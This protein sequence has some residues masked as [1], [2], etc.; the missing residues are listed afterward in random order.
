MPLRSEG[1]SFASADTNTER[2]LHAVKSTNRLSQ[3]PRIAPP[4]SARAAGDEEEG[5][6]EEETPPL[7]PVTTPVSEPF[8]SPVERIR[9]ILR[10]PTITKEE[11]MRI[12]LL[13]TKSSAHLQRII[14]QNPM[15][16]VVSVLLTGIGLG[17]LM[18][19]TLEQCRQMA[20]QVKDTQSSLKLSSARVSSA[21]SQTIDKLWPSKP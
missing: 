13:T 16:T 7:D 9:E 18:G 6:S 20:N 17:T 15:L 10:D 3:P 1:L 14:V 21:D 2:M 19:R 11:R 5:V 12:R 4:V 8:V